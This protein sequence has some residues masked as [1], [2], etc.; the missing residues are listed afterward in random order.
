MRRP[1][2]LLA[3]TVVAFG[4]LQALQYCEIPAAMAYSLKMPG[5]TNVK[6]HTIDRTSASIE[7]GAVNCMSYVMTNATTTLTQGATYTFSIAHTRDE[8]FFPDT[9]NNIR[10]WIDYN[11]DG[12]FAE[13]AETAL[14]LNYQTFGTSTGQITIPTTATAGPTRMRV[15]AK[16]SD[17]AGHALPTPCNVPADDLGYHG[18]I[19][20]YTVTIV[21]STTSV[22]ELEHASNVRIVPNPFVE[23]TTIELP[24]ATERASVVVYD[25]LGGRVI[26]VDQLGAS[27]IRMDRGTLTSGVYVMYITLD[28]APPIVRVVA[29]K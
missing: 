25:V 5:I 26:E 14:A 23:S 11:H 9:R 2:V 19:E 29:M 15:T 16:M 13:P 22:D 7:C 4:T 6:L 18:E 21:Q 17:D 10:V 27:P 20:D 8:D 24:A 1:V 3:A 12:I 28:A